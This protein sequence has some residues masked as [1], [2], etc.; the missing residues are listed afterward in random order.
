M[1]LDHLT[2]TSNPALVWSMGETVTHAD[3]KTICLFFTCKSNKSCPL[4]PATSQM[5]TQQASTKASPDSKTSQVTNFPRQTIDS[6][7]QVSKHLRQTA[8]NQRTALSKTSSQTLSMRDPLC[9]GKVSVH[10]STSTGSRKKRR[11]CQLPA[12]TFPSQNSR[13]CSKRGSE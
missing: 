11:S 6:E 5:S 9:S 12:S 8:T 10:S 13:E 4:Q 3:Q 1:S 7:L 2:M